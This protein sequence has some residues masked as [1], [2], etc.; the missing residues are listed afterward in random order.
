[1]RVRDITNGYVENVLEHN[2]IEAY[3]RVFPELFEHYFTYW[4]NKKSFHETL[5]V[6]QVAERVRLIT[7]RLPI[8][9]S[10][11]SERGFNTADTEIVLFVGQDTTNGHAFEHNGK[12]MVWLPIET[13]DDSVN[14]NVF[15]THEIIH[16]LHYAASRG[17]YFHTKEAKETTLRQL[18]TEGIATYVSREVLNI[19]TETALWGSYL[20]GIE[21]S[22]WVTRCEE[23]VDA[24]WS[25]VRTQIEGGKNAGTLF[26]ANNPDDV[27]TYRAGYW[28]GLL[29]IETYQKEKDVS[30]RELLQVPKSEFLKTI[31]AKAK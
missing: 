21:A 13:Y 23:E 12:Y 6:E 4:A 8:I 20:S 15:V 9:E 5:N 29:I 14:V 3:F 11:L 10:A 16:A 25:E 28:L 17:Y 18:I 30:L 22:N 2:E 24:L 26:M 31:E 7:S 1:M 27:R 19:S